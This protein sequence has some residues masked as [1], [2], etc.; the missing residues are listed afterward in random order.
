MTLKELRI[1][2]GLS[3]NGLA[4]LAGLPYNSVKRAES[5]LPISAPTAKA[6]ADALSKAMQREIK[7]SDIEG[8]I[9]K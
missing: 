7:P 4:E 9:I 2:V 5:G 3:M 1:N 8:L 6:I